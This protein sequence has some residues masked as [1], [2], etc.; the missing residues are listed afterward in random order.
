MYP[1]MTMHTLIL[2]PVSA[3][4]FEWFSCLLAMDGLTTGA[5]RHYFISSGINYHLFGVVL[6]RSSLYY[7]SR[8]F[9][10]YDCLKSG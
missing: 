5:D 8:N 9:P 2:E 6:T 3:A 4:H 1:D 7:V 10:C